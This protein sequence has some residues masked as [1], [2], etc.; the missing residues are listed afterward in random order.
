MAEDLNNATSIDHWR[1]EW[2]LT[3]RTLR[4]GKAIYFH[5]VW[6]ADRTGL[7]AMLQEGILGLGFDAIFKDFELTSYSIAGARYHDQWKDRI[8][9]INALE[10]RTLTDKFENYFLNTLKIPQEEIDYFRSVMLEDATMQ[11]V[12]INEGLSC[13][14]LM[15]RNR[16]SNQMS[17]GSIPSSRP[18]SSSS[19]R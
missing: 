14:P 13:M 6:G 17:S 12:V 15:T 4:A 2:A 19:C 1:K 9:V 16:G 5:C 10:G 8:S 7:W 11:P 18:R 3:L